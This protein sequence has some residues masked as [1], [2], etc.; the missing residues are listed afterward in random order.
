MRLLSL[1]VTLAISPLG[2]QLVAQEAAPTD[3]EGSWLGTMNAGG[4]QLRMRIDLTVEDGALGAR[5]FSV[6]QGNAEIPVESATVAGGTLSLTMPMIGGSYE[7]TLSDDGQTIDGTFQQMG[8]ELPLVLERMEGDEPDAGRP[9]DPVEPYPY[10]AE[11]VRYPNPDGG[12]ELAGTFTRPSDGGPFPAV[13]L[14]TGSGPQNRDEALLGHRPFLVLS[15][16]LTRRGIAVLRFDDRGVGESTGDHAAATSSDFASDA[17]AG[18]AYLKTRDDVDP[19]AIGLAG[20]S[21]GG[22]IA[23][24][25]ATRSDDV[26]YIVLMA[27]TGVNGERILYAQGALINRAAGAT[28]EQIERNQ[29]LQRAMFEILKSEPD[30]ERAAAVLTETVRTAFEAMPDAQRAQAGITDDESLDR[31]VNMQVTQFNTPWFRYFLTY[32]PATVIEQVTVPVLA[33]NGEKDLQVPYEENLR[34]IEAA[35]HRGGNTN[36]EIHA[37]PD[38]NHLFQHSET[39][40]PS[41]YATIEETWSVDVM[42]LIADWI[43]RTTGR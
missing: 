13:I 38:L 4:A 23:P 28:E 14:I 42:E 15:D 19:A 35:L 17:L 36:Y 5:M 37:L 7:G 40:A 22:L 18:V 27:G 2:A 26:S 31:V 24:I 9:Q 11:D 41:E 16:H 34:E 20:H 12:H 32:E 30:P 6:D 10:V 43:L 29:E 1:C 21:E 39:G 25:A 3:F 33:I 8:A